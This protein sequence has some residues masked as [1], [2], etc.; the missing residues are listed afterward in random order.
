MPYA[1]L[2][3]TAS[4]DQLSTPSLGP[5]PS[6]DCLRMPF[7][8]TLTAPHLASSG[9]ILIPLWLLKTAN[10]PL[11]GLACDSLSIGRIEN[12]ESSYARSVNPAQLCDHLWSPVALTPY[13]PVWASQ[14]GPTAPCKPPL[15]PQPQQ[16]LPDILREFWKA[17]IR[18]ASSQAASVEFEHPR[19]SPQSQLQQRV[20]NRSKS[21]W[22][23]ASAICKSPVCNSARKAGSSPLAARS[24]RLR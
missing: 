21:D 6:R 20:W 19:P 9:P 11:N 3:S 4:R 5:V 22:S 24:Q 16:G 2:A 7:C 23:P 10:E 17:G 18:I 12:I 13:G 15:H 1:P 8:A 14:F